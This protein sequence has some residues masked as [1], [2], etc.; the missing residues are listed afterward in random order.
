M[1]MFSWILG[2]RSSRLNPIEAQIIEALASAL[3]GKAGD[4]LRSQ[5]AL[6]NK[7]QRLDQ[8]REVDFYHIEKGKPMFPDIALFPN[9]SEEFELAKLKVLS[10]IHI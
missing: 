2:N 10:L 9:Q 1:K 8:D 3:N 4:L 7:V 5:V 6:I